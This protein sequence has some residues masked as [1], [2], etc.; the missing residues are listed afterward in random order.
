MHALSWFDNRTLIAC[1]LLLATVFAVVFFS[2]KRVYPTLRG[3][4]SIAASFLL[5]V[6]GT[7]MMVS[8]SSSVT[9]FLTV[10][11]AVSFILG[12]FTFLYR[13]ILR[14]IGSRRSAVVPLLASFL[15]LAIFYYFSEVQ[16]SIAARL[17]AISV[18]IGVIRGMIALEL[19]RKS[20]TFTSPVVMRLFAASM[21]FFAAVSLNRGVLTFLYGAPADYFEKNVIQTSTLALGVVSVCLTGLFIL[22]LSS[23]ELIARSR[24]D[25]QKDV[26]CGALNRRG[27]EAKLAA[28]LK[29]IRRGKQ[30]LSIALIDVDYFKS[31]ND[32]QGHAAGDAALRDVVDAI[33]SRLRGR[34][35]LGRYGGDEF[36]LI[37]PQTAIS[38]ALVIVERLNQ[39][40]ST[41]SLS[42]RSQ[43]LTLSIGLTE[44]VAD[45]DAVTLIARADKALYQ[46]KSDGRNCRRVGMLE[47]AAAS[48]DAPEKYL[49]AV[50]MPGIEPTLLQ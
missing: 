6:P 40:V 1:D 7:F 4:G 35:H 20:P 45:D 25:S 13:G 43:P 24:D 29:H 31:I 26:L 15:C 50:L 18:T 49:G 19:F 9:R 44:A 34:D 36:L 11:L 3:V 10:M 28:E 47:T 42:G 37:F 5:G 21:S 41:L 12:S 16:P 48:E 17:I 30:K 46:A 39:A 38:I 27:I 23:N 32:F 2:M 14:F 33:S 22:I 8:S